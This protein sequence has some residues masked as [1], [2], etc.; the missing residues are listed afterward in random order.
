MRSI[1]Y[2]APNQR[3]DAHIG[4]RSERLEMRDTLGTPRNR[5]RAI[6]ND[7]RDAQAAIDTGKRVAQ[8]TFDFR[9]VVAL[10]MRDRDHDPDAPLLHVRVV[11]R[12]LRDKLAS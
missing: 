4:H 5:D 1:L 7:R 9:A 8:L 2:I 11:P 12:T 10:E 6:E 3:I